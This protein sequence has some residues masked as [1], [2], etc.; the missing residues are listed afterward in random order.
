MKIEFNGNCI[1]IINIISLLRFNQV[2]LP[3]GLKSQ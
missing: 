3:D 2:D 1:G